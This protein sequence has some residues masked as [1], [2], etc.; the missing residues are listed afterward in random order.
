MQRLLGEYCREGLG[1]TGI[2]APHKDGHVGV[3]AGDGEK[4]CLT[5]LVPDVLAKADPD[6]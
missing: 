1:L 4:V 2:E 6:R 3:F 5:Y